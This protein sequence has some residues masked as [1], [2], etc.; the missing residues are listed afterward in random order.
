MMALRSEVDA[1]PD[2]RQGLVEDISQRI[3]SGTYN[4]QGQLVAEA[5]VNHAAF[6]AVA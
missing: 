2:V 6:E 1:A 5:M 3:A 4:I